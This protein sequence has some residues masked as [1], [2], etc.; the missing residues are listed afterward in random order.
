MILEL[1][2]FTRARTRNPCF[3]EKLSGSLVV[4]VAAD[5][6]PLSPGLTGLSIPGYELG[7][8]CLG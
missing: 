5:V 2:M 1:F 6:W 3:E 8:S 7:S 4:P